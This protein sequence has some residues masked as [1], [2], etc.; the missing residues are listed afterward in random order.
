MPDSGSSEN[1]HGIMVERIEI[2]SMRSIRLMVPKGKGERE[3]DGLTGSL[4]W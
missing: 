4:G 3:R 1:V 2:F